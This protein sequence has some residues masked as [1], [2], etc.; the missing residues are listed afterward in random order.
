MLPIRAMRLHRPEK[1][2]PTAD[3]FR[4]GSSNFVVPT[5]RCRDNGGLAIPQSTTAG[6]SA[7]GSPYL[8]QPGIGRR[9]L[10]SDME[11]M[12]N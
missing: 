4:C 9:W 2:W 7:S 5:Y 1:Q 8:S 10:G 6:Q 12:S 11:S 3:A